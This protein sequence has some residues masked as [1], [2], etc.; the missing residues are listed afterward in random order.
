MNGTNQHLNPNFPNSLQND[1][2]QRKQ[3][4][5]NTKVH[6]IVTPITQLKNK[7][8]KQSQNWKQLGVTA[9]PTDFEISIKADQILLIPAP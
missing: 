3:P 1:L 9:S 8:K 2:S 4:Q 5:L 6:L 7:T